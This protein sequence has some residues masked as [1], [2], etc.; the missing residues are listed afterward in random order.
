MR[1]TTTP[2]TANISAQD[3]NLLLMQSGN[4]KIEE[5]LVEDSIMSHTIAEKSRS[6]STDKSGSHIEPSSLLLKKAAKKEAKRSKKMKAV[7]ERPN[8]EA[9]RAEGEYNKMILQ[10]SSSDEISIVKPSATETGNATSPDTEY[11]IK[12]QGMSAQEIRKID[13]FLANTKGQLQHKNQTATDKPVKDNQ[14]LNITTN[15]REGEPP[16]ATL[17]QLTGASISGASGD[18]VGSR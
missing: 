18:D 13:D 7:P 3:R 10:T 2:N 14:L 16:V 17:I 1:H 4:S 8:A 9:I 11:L 12:A 5:E 6:I 15:G